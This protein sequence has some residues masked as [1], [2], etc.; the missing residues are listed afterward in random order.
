M[1][2]GGRGEGQGVAD[3]ESDVGPYTQYVMAPIHP[4]TSTVTVKLWPPTMVLPQM[5]Q[6]TFLH[7]SMTPHLPLLCRPVVVHC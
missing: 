7:L 5:S 4:G 3:G 1:Y 6:R 2:V